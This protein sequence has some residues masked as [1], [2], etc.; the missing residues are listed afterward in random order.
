MQKCQIGD[1]CVLDGVIIDKDAKVEPGVVLKGA[2]DQPKETFKR[3]FVVRVEALCGKP[4]AESTARDHYHVLGQ[5]VRE[6][7]SRHWITTNERYRAQRWKQVYYL[8]IE[9]LLGRLLGNNLLNLGV[10]SVVEEGLRELGIRLEDVEEC[11]ADAG[12]GNGGLGRMSAV[13]IAHS[14]YFAS[15]RTVAEYAAEIWGISPSM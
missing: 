12:L 14:G 13:N 7:I 1:G 11:K 15:D 5:M 6:H 8:S 10:R 2:A 9:F 4:F 3:A